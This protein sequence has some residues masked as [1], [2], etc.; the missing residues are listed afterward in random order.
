MDKMPQKAAEFPFALAYRSRTEPTAQIAQSK[1]PA[2]G[3]HTQQKWIGV[4]WDMTPT[5]DEIEVGGMEEREGDQGRDMQRLLA[6]G[7]GD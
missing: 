5:G 7:H 6:P 2:K 3:H 4:P 1:E